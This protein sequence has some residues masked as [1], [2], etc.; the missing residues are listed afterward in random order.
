MSTQA[1]QRVLPLLLGGLLLAALGLPFLTQAPNRLV[2]GTG[3]LLAEVAQGRRALV[4]APLLLWLLALARPASARST[5]LLIA[6][7]AAGTIAGLTW[8][9]GSHAAALVSD[10]LPLGRTSL[11]GGYWVLIV[12]CG[13]AASEA[14][15][16]PDVPRLWPPAVGL[17]LLGPL[18]TLLLQG[19]LDQLSLM[20]EYDNR[21]DV[22]DAALQ[23]HLLLVAATLLA[24]LL[25]A[26]PTGVLIS[27]RATLAAPLLALLNLVQ[28]VPSI[29]LF[30]L[31]MGPLAA[32]SARWPLL[33][34]WGI[35]GIGPA[36][37]IIALTLY[38]LLPMVRSISAGLGQVAPTVIESARGMG[39]SELQIFRQVELPLA[40]PVW[41]AGL[42]VTTVQAIGLAV[43]AALIGA[44]GF[45]A[46]MFQGLLSS[47]L[48][49]VLLGVLP[50]V[51]LSVLADSL[52][53]L[54]AG[55]LSAHRTP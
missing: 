32:L 13:L 51:G 42:R 47:A 11:G 27:R 17:L 36:P 31:L 4:L 16:G 50:V 29:A 28:T 22:F 46:V 26:V 33:A 19:G 44:G 48:D 24:T 20:K 43:V 53:K 38:S 6:L 8:L 49:L 23:R 54:I 39:M 41:L 3:L 37:A 7:G 18:A 35:S 45:G 5:R 30:A 40:L 52:F 14:A 2:T 21:Q 55:L 10:D 9:A 34:Q 25:I 15:R 12:L 1:H